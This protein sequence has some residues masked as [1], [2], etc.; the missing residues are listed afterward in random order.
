MST[1]AGQ[2][3]HT[4]NNIKYTAISA[5]RLDAMR[6]GGKDEHGNPWDL[7]AAEGWEPLRC[8]LRKPVE[9]EEIALICY[10]PWTEPSPWAEAGPVFVHYRRCAGYDATDEY[11]GEFLASRSILNPF[12]HTGARAYDHITFLRPEDDHEAAVRAVLAEPNVAFLHV[13]SATAGCFHFKARP[14]V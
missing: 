3:G 5:D 14:A 11:P 12:D 7:R 8:C 6:T 1:L 13:R 4:M 10:T 9:G 2:T